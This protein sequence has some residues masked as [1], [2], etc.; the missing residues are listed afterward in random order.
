M[1]DAHD[2][3][4][5]LDDELVH[6]EREAPLARDA[7]HVLWAD[8]HFEGTTFE[9]RLLQEDGAEVLPAGLHLPIVAVGSDP[10]A[11]GPF[12]QVDPNLHDVAPVSLGQQGGP[13]A[14]A[15]RELLTGLVQSSESDRC[16]VGDLELFT[17]A[18]SGSGE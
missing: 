4:A 8:G 16:C 17:P 14:V 7:P 18:N 1:V 15:G 5:F 10:D 3:L 11:G 9:I 2:R 13:A 12:A 6:C